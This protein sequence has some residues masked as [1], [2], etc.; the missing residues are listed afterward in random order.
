MVL[1]RAM[2]ADREDELR[3]QPVPGPGRRHGIRGDRGEGPRVDAVGDQGGAGG[4]R[5]VLTYVGQAGPGRRGGRGGPA[6]DRPGG[7]LQRGLAKPAAGEADVIFDRAVVQGHHE[8]ARPDER[9]ER[10]I[11][12]VE[13]GRSRRADDPGEFPAAVHRP[14]RDVGVD[15]LGVGGQP[16]QREDLLPAAVHEYPQGEP[17]RGPGHVPGQLHHRT[18]DPVRTGKGVHPRVDQD[19]TILSHVPAPLS[20]PVPPRPGRGRPAPR[21]TPPAILARE[22]LCPHP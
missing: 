1:V 17:V 3:R 15:H 6:Q 13:H 2:G 4:G 16:G 7:H 20:V 11:R 14:G 10:R 21:R 8:R 19:R 12:H 18:G 9:R 5:V 22:P